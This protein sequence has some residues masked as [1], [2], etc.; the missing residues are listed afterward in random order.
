[1]QGMQHC[2]FR[3]LYSV[4]DVQRMGGES[5]ADGQSARKGG[6]LCSEHCI[7]F[8]DPWGVTNLAFVWFGVLGLCLYSISP[9]LWVQKPAPSKIDSSKSQDNLF[10]FPPISLNNSI[11]K[12]T[13]KYEEHCGGTCK[14]GNLDGSIR[15]IR[16]HRRRTRKPPPW[17]C[18]TRPVQGRLISRRQTPTGGKS[19]RVERL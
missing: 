4:E 7:L 18:W 14:I 15:L 19:V 3:V 1:M 13:V 5:H 8:S 9:V 6:G 2:G 16:R 10:G 17:R 11:C 12:K